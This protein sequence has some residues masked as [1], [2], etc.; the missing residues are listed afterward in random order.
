MNERVDGDY[1]EHADYAALRSK[2]D[3]LLGEVYQLRDD[4]ANDVRTNVWAVDYIRERCDA[5][6]ENA[7]KSEEER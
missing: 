7:E 3:A 6:I 1:V 5:A 4:A 2:C